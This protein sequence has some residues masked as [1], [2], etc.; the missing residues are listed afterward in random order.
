MLHHLTTRPARGLAAALFAL[1]LLSALHG[2]GAAQDGDKK[3]PI[4][5]KAAQKEADKTVLEIFKEDIDKAR[6][7]PARSKLAGVLLQQG[8]ETT[9]DPAARYVL[10]VYARDL[11]AQAGDAPLTLLAVDEIAKVYDV[12]ALQAKADV[13]PTVVANLTE[14]EPSKVLVDVALALVNEAVDQDN[15]PAAK[16]LGE[17]A[18]NAAKKSKSF[19]M[20]ASVKKRVDE[21]AVVEKGFSKMQPYLDRIKKDPTDAEANQE[22]GKYFAL[23]KGKW[24]RGLPHLAR[25]SDE[26]I[27]AQALKDLA[28]PKESAA[29]LAVADGWW[30]LALKEQEPAGA[31]MKVRAGYWYEEALGGLSG[32]NRTKALKRIDQVAA[33][34]KTTDTIPELPPVKVG[35][36]HVFDRH[37]REVKC[38]AISPDGKYGLSGSVDNT[39]R[40]WNLT[41]GKEVRVFQGHT[42]EIWGCTFTTDGKPVSASW[43]A[44][45]KVWD[46]VSGKELKSFVHP[47]DVNGVTV[48]RDGKWLLT[49]CDD[50]AARLWDLKAGQAASETRRYSG[51]TQYCYGVA[52]S[53]DMKYV[54]SGGSQDRTVRVYNFATGNLVREI[55]GQNHAVNCVA[56][57][58]DGKYV[59]S[60]GD[61][62][63]HVWEVATGKEYKR[64]QVS[65]T[66]Y[67]NAM[68]LSPD[69]RRLLTGHDDKTV[70]LWDVASGKQ[71]HS[72]TG[73]TGTV[74]AVAFSAD[75][76]R[77]ISGGND[78]TVRL[79]GLP[80]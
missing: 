18:Y 21:V 63:A 71:I 47:K 28:R 37:A 79:W 35:P 49:G 16:A 22:L 23:L 13:L 68:A 31:N 61:N 38:V 29:Q 67:V 45:V 78:N 20:V 24:S 50:G 62:A 69:G 4:P 43:D 70:R 80:R 34:G 8:R 46:P 44:T 26:K 9:T 36:L 32:L 51:H 57:S 10:Y 60:C 48:S 27:K 6:D 65:A 30:E 52:F 39:L 11:A 41:D 15:Y 40:L 58:P 55:S 72:F 1:L 66:E 75:G 17:V 54:A 3:L 53:P 19:A 12:P 2:P 42:K 56:F 25:G 7:A 76:R 5:D 77:A 74:I 33:L 64:F 73:H 14:V 59:F